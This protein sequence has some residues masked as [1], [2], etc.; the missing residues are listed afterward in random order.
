MTPLHHQ[1]LLPSPVYTRQ[2]T[3]NALPRPPSLYPREHRL[4]AIWLLRSNVWRRRRPPAPATTSSKQPERFV[5]VPIVLCALAL[6]QVF[7]SRY[8]GYVSISTIFAQR[9]ARLISAVTACVHFPHHCPCAWPDQEDKF[10]LADGSRSCVSKGGFKDGE[11]ARK[12]ELARKGL[13]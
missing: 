7:V 8:I 3:Q 12:V 5:A 9:G 13:L 10:E 11:A 2:N 4:G 6:R 1:Q